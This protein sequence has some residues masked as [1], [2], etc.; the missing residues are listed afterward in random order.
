M[1]DWLGP[2]FIFRVVKNIPYFVPCEVQS[3]TSL[4]SSPSL[5]CGKK[6]P[7]F[8]RKTFVDS[9]LQYVNK[10]NQLPHIIKQKQI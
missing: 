1:K 3:F 2:P 5:K 6:F 8:Y 10:V 4:Q 9:I 7:G